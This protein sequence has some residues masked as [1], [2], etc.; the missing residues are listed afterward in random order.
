MEY[1]DYYQILGVSRD[2]SPEDLKKA[3]RKLAR[4]YHPDVSKEANAE[5][6]FKEVGEAYEALKD[7]EKR[8]QY[9]RFG[10][11]YKNGQ[12]FTPPPGWGAGHGGAGDFSSFFESMFG[13]GSRRGGGSSDSFFAQGEDVNAKIT[14]SLEDAFH[15]TQK[16]IRRPNGSNQ[17]GT[18][19]VKIPAGITAGKK[20][21]LSGQ[22]KAGMGGSAGDLLLEIAIAPHA[23]YRLE[24]KDIYLDL[25]IAPWEA[26]LGAKVTVPTLAGRI[27][28]SIP[29]GA[30]SGQKMRLKGRGLPSKEP[31][32]QFVVL[33]IMTPPADT[34]KAKQLYQ[35]M[36]EEMTFNPRETLENSL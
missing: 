7:P 28:L 25:P 11:N 4:K 33:Q 12:S 26:A 36:A 23:F 21:R 9:D 8:A 15:G 2:V 3:Y 5:A 27:N 10:S 30:K 20:I 29:A 17:T 35:Q 31:G 34:D 14:I 22:G 16:A 32:D 6:K 18:L 24:D 1:K 13:G 19:N